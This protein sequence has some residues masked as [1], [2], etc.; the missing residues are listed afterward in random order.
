[1]Q[2]REKPLHFSLSPQKAHLL[3]GKNPEAEGRR[4]RRLQSPDQR[5]NARND[6]RPGPRSHHPR[7]ASRHDR[8]H[9]VFPYSPAPACAS[10]SYFNSR[11]RR[12]R[13]NEIKPRQI[14]GKRPL[15]E[16]LP[17]SISYG[18]LRT[19]IRNRSFI[20]FANGHHTARPHDQPLFPHRNGIGGR[21][22]RNPGDA[23][24]K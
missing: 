11:S 1:M 15:E 18:S 5:H 10:G 17:C 16:R 21:N 14:N 22:F 13:Q 24:G 23:A 6:G 8:H 2:N 9:R 7:L 12:P 20:L 3:P 19:E 4:F